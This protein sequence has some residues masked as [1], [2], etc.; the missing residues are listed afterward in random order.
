MGY[1]EDQ[2][3]RIC[4]FKLKILEKIIQV[5]NFRGGGL[6]VSLVFG[7]RPGGMFRTSQA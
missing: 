3:P 5:K 2:T 4:F 1:D 7:V 6:F